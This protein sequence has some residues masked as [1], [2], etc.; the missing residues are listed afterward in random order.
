MM[1]PG[2]RLFFFS[3]FILC[4]IELLLPKLLSGPFQLTLFRCLSLLD[5]PFSEL[6][7]S[8]HGIIRRNHTILSQLRFNSTSEKPNKARQSAGLV[9]AT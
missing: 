2:G 8:Y 5:E 6:E 3:T 4:S 7:N 1:Q 9:T